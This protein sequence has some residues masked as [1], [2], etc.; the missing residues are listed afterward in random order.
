M[1][2]GFRIPDGFEEALRPPVDV[3][4][5]RLTPA[6]LRPGRQGHRSLGIRF[7]QLAR[8]APEVMVKVTGRTRDAAHL[9]AH[10][11]YISRNGEL[12]LGTQDGERLEGR[13]AIGALGAD[14]AAEMEMDAGRRR[15]SPVSRSIV[16]SMPA[17]TDPRRLEEAAVAFAREVFA[18]RFPWVSVLHDEGRHPHVHLTVR[19]LGTGGERLNPRKADLQLWRELFAARLRERDIPAEATPRRARGIVMKAERAPVRRMRERFMAGNG[20][21]PRVLEAAHLEA[22][23]AVAD[24]N[25]PWEGAIQA[26]QSAIRRAYLALALVLARSGGQGDR[27]LAADLDRFVGGMPPVRTRDAAMRERL[28]RPPRAPPERDRG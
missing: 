9:R 12:A 20:P 7:T 14:W 13:A 16:L 24:R 27:E 21:L 15:D 26:R 17:G 3:G 8:R 22:R 23:A 5:A 25:R 28:G 1:T 11:D 19:A 18:D 2:G 10:L 6:I 4:R